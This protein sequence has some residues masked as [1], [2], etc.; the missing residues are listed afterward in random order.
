M[1]RYCTGVISAPPAGEVLLDGRTVATATP[2]ELKDVPVGPHVVEVRGKGLWIGIELNCAARPFCEALKQR[3]VLC[4]ET[5]EHVIRLAP[6]LII[7]KAENTMMRPAAV[8]A[9]TI[10]IR[11]IRFQAK[12]IL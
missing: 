4:K 9:K 6:A 11:L 3:G 8:T 2:A 7:S 12:P 1:R 10:P 5:H